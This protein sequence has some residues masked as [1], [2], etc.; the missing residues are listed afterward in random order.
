VSDFCAEGAVVHEEDV[1]ILDVM[2]NELLES[3]G[4]EEFG[5]VV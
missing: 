1:E 3:V 4:K 2:N 5:G